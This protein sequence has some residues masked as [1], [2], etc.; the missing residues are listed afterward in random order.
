MLE[1][2]PNVVVHQPLRLSRSSDRGLGRVRLGDHLHE[3]AVRVVEVDAP[4]AVE[5]VDLPGLLAKRI[6]VV[7]NARQTSGPPGFRLRSFVT[8]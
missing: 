5:V 8:L 4:S 2:V 7:G 6:R 1:V 3:M